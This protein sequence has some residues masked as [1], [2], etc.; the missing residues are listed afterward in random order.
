[1]DGLLGF[2]AAEPDEVAAFFVAVGGGIEGVAAINE[3]EGEVAFFVEEFGNDEGGSGGLVRGDDFAEVAGGE[4]E[5][6]L[7]KGFLGD[8]GTMSGREFL[9]KL[10]AEL[11]DLQDA[12]N[13]FIRTLF[14]NGVKEVVFLT[15]GLDGWG[16]GKSV[17]IWSQ[18]SSICGQNLLLFFDCRERNQARN[19]RKGSEELGY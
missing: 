15:V 7:G 2:G 11:V 10:A 13:M 8:G 12:Q 6:S 4:F 18:S 9:A 17:L 19:E 1:M 14:K 3:S 5:R 16:A